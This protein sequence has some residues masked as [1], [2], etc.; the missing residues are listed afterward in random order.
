MKPPWLLSNEEIRPNLQSCEIKDWVHWT[1]IDNPD[2]ERVC[3]IDKES[4]FRKY[5]PG[6][7]SEMIKVMEF[8]RVVWVADGR[9][10]VYFQRIA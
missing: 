1:E 6:E 10:D 3:C 2:A 9:D 5:K 8:R 4:L 7:S